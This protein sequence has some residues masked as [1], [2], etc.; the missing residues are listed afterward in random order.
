[1]KNEQ[2]N[3]GETAAILGALELEEGSRPPTRNRKSK[4]RCH[5]RFQLR[6]SRFPAILSYLFTHFYNFYHI[7]YFT[8]HMR[9]QN[10]RNTHDRHSPRRFPSRSPSIEAMGD[11]TTTVEETDV[12]VRHIASFLSI[13]D[14]ASLMSNKET[15]GLPHTDSWAVGV[16]MG[17]LSPRQNETCGTSWEE[18]LM[19][20]Q[21]PAF[22]SVSPGATPNFDFPRDHHH[23]DRH[24]HFS[25]ESNHEAID[26]NDEDY[27]AMEEILWERRRRWVQQKLAAAVYSHPGSVRSFCLQAYQSARDILKER[28][29]KQPNDSLE[30]PETAIEPLG[31]NVA[32]THRGPRRRRVKRRKLVAVIV[33]SL[34]NNVPLSVFIDVLIA[35]GETTLDT[36][37]ASFTIVGRSLDALVQG[38]LRLLQS[39][40]NC[41][42]NFNPFQ[43]LNAI[44]SFQFNAMGKTSEV[45]ASGIQS[46]ATGVGSASSLA[47]HRL[48]AANL[49]VA[50]RVTGAASSSSLRVEGTGVR[51][52]R[53]SA[54]ALNEKLLRKL[55][56]MN[57]A[58]RVVLYV[59]SED[60]TGGLT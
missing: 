19:A 52:S 26:M 50:T 3:E 60:E 59:E 6:A 39:V 9:T 7:H 4:E 53:S 58:A 33:E 23:N 36:T 25:H 30:D 12:I 40:W 5:V 54:T 32:I 11:N 31:E 41:I 20:P 27:D 8:F 46:V 57:D 49:S 29:I 2:I 16:D 21:T 45:L 35:L 47:L 18:Q 13:S 28:K 48:S 51:R 1:M 14:A 42:C 22:I 17:S 56:T 55:S 38:T 37:F 43:L 15:D 44:V 34:L 10:F 24:P